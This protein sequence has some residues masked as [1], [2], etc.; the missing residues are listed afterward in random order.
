MKVGDL[1]APQGDNIFVVFQKRW[2]MSRSADSYMGAP[3]SAAFYPQNNNAH[4][5]AKVIGE[6]EILFQGLK[7]AVWPAEEFKVTIKENK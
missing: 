2:I 5:I 4:R 7:L 3:P 6:N 1:I